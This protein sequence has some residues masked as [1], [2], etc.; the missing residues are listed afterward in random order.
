MAVGAA[1]AAGNI[2]V[3]CKRSTIPYRLD[4]VATDK[5]HYLEKKPGFDDVY[6][7]CL[8]KKRWLSVD[9]AVHDAIQPGRR[10]RKERWS[11]VIYVD[12]QPVEIGFSQDTRNMLRLMPIAVALMAG[13]A[14]LTCWE[15][16]TPRASRPQADAPSTQPAK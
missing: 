2:W 4:G 11:R 5:D 9:Q 16:R 13:L 6:L 3:A 8:D 15:Q 7:V 14:A 10:V 1:L 12:N